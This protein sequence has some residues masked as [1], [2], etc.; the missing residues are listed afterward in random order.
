[1]IIPNNKTNS[2]FDILILDGYNNSVAR[3]RVQSLSYN[4]NNHVY[5][6]VVIF[7]LSSTLYNKFDYVKQKMKKTK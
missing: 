2:I 5:L 1:M 4:D 3:L 6:A 7:V